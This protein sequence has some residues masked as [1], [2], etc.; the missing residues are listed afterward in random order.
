VTAATITKSFTLD[1]VA[2]IIGIASTLFAPLITFGVSH[3]MYGARI[4]E[5]EARNQDH[6]A[7]I[8]MMESER[9]LLLASMARVETR[10]DMLMNR[11]DSGHK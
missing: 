11:T 2:I 3:V 5:V 7:R 10:L 4:T 9:A 1:R 6:E 8:R